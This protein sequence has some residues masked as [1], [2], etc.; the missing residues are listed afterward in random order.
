MLN[1][2]GFAETLFRLMQGF[3]KDKM[4]NR[5]VVHSKGD[6][7][8]LHEALGTQ[9][10]PVEYGGSN[11]AIK[12]HVGEEA[13]A[14]THSKAFAPLDKQAKILKSKYMPLLLRLSNFFYRPAL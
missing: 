8:A 14:R 10:L 12:D 4:K 9:V 7:S 13:V 6:L 1:M 2:P 5:M 11:G 3:M